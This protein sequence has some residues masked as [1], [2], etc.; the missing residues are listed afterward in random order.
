MSPECPSK[1]VVDIGVGAQPLISRIH[2]DLWMGGV[3]PDYYLPEWVDHL[4]NMHPW[5]T[6]RIDHQL[7]THVQVRCS[8]SRD[9][10]LLPQQ[11]L[12]LGRYVW[13]CATQGPTVVHCQA[14]MNR[15]GLITASALMAGGLSLQEAV[16]LIRRYRNTNCLFNG[17]FV[18]MLEGIE[19]AHYGRR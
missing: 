8:D 18:E 9:P 2:L 5:Q 13:E 17:H 19:E 1:A 14:G 16:C 11:V 3:H 12:H 15:S 6:Y 7:R 4:F 10:G